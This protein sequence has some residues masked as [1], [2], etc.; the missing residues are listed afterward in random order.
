MSPRYI[1]IK[2]RYLGP[3]AGA[4]GTSGEELKI[5][6]GAE[7]GDIMDFMIFTYPII[8]EIFPPGVL[9]FTL[10]GAVPEVASPLRDGAVVE[11]S[12]TSGPR[13]KP[14][15][16]Q[17]KTPFI[18]FVDEHDK[19][20]AEAL[21]EYINWHGRLPRDVNTWSD[22]RVSSIGRQLLS[23]DLP[24]AQW[25]DAIHVL[26]HHPSAVALEALHALNQLEHEPWQ[27]IW[28]RQALD[29]CKTFNKER[30]T[31]A[32]SGPVISPVGAARNK[33]CPCGSGKKFKNC[34]GRLL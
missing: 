7:F 19:Q 18:S 1:T 26:A 28:I 16:F 31:G 32:K 9:G 27:K 34:C 17:G 8:Q 13:V 25:K 2:L 22:E 24:A 14:P 6:A 15:D 30:L 33:P 21:K 20:G 5:P 29:E 4:L 11:F 10:D 23:E 3:V 12:A